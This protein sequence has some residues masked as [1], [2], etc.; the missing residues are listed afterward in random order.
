MLVRNSLAML[1]QRQLVAAP[2]RCAA[3]DD[4]VPV[5]MRPPC[6]IMSDAIRE[7]SR[8][9]DIPLVLWSVDTGDAPCAADRYKSALACCSEM[10]GAMRKE[11]A[12][13]SIVLMHTIAPSSLAIYP[14]ADLLAHR[15]LQGVSL[16]TLQGLST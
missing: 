8:Q 7:L 6:G 16:S 3:G 5:A 13:G 1:P 12:P 9:Y 11:L 4:F 15:N 14:I 2:N 10:L